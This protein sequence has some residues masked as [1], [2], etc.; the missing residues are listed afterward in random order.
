MVDNETY[1]ISEAAMLTGLHRNTIRQRIRLGQLDAR[2]HPGKFGDEY[3]VSRLSLRRAGLL[4]GEPGEPEL[5]PL[6]GEPVIPEPVEAGDLEADLAAEAISTAAPEGVDGVP[7]GAL[8]P[9]TGIEALTE[10]YRRHE[11]AMFRLG[12]IQAEVE[13]LKALA[14]Q[15]ESLAEAEREHR[16]ELESLR[17]TAA[18]REREA[19][20]AG[21]LREEVERLRG[22]AEDRERQAAE[23]MRLR[24]ELERSQARAAE[25]GELRREVAQL[26]TLAEQPSPWWR[27]WRN[28]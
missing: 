13:R 26:K 20:E 21:R 8:S 5:P 2:V 11:Q 22:L 25:L 27:F 15:A 1:T 12:Y 14:A 17:R 6:E 19:A 7:E 23:A 4:P 3:R 18:E 9:G 10:L 16:Q 28:R 24:E